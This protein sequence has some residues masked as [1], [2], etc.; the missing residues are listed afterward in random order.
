[1]KESKKYPESGI[2]LFFLGPLYLILL[3]LNGTYSPYQSGINRSKDEKLG[4]KLI[5]M[6]LGT[7]FYVVLLIIITSYGY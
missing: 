4:R 7:M 2:I 3:K 1:M 6:S 5:L